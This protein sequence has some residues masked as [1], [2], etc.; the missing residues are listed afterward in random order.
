MEKET[1]TKQLLASSINNEL[2]KEVISSHDIH[3]QETDVNGINWF[4][5]SKDDQLN[6]ILEP[7]KTH[8]EKIKLKFL[9]MDEIQM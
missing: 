1:V 2:K 3:W 4:I 5:Q 9:I 7:V 6:Q 8:I